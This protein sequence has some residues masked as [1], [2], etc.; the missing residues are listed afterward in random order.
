MKKLSI[1]DL[2]A[3]VD[4]SDENPPNPDFSLEDFGKEVAEG[5]DSKTARD[6][7]F[8]CFTRLHHNVAHD[9]L[10]GF[11]SVAHVDELAELLFDRL[12]SS[13]D[14]SASATI[15]EILIRFA[16]LSAAEV[17]EGLLDRFATA[18]DE[19]VQAN[20]SYGVWALVCMYCWDLRDD[21]TTRLWTYPLGDPVS[22]RLVHRLE[23]ELKRDDISKYARDTFSEC[24]NGILRP[25]EQGSQ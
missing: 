6:I 18:D 13:D 2:I 8:A 16:K 7:V 15:V 3:V 24:I 1:D 4:A 5:W 10:S 14:V 12:V 20:L 11:L 25:P 23:G 21:S 19:Q 17:A 9:F 22:T